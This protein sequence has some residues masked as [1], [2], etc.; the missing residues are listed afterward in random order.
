VS[1]NLSTPVTGL[2]DWRLWARV[3]RTGVNASGQELFCLPDIVFGRPL[4]MNALDRPRPRMI[5]DLLGRIGSVR[6]GLP[7]RRI[8]SATCRH[9]RPSSMMPVIRG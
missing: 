2:S 6:Q 3:E 8:C 1:V 5:N 7:P 9:V 4:L